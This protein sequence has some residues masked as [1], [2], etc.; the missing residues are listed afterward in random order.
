MLSAKENDITH[1]SHSVLDE[2]IGNPRFVHKTKTA[3]VLK[4]TIPQ[5]YAP[6][7][8][9]MLVPRI[10]INEMYVAPSLCHETLHA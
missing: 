6:G 2:Y 1:K 10:F 9:L 4:R 3:F 5:R 8:L 7:T